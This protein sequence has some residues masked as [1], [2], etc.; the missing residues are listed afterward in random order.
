MGNIAPQ[1][2]GPTGEQRDELRRSI[3]RFARLLPPGAERNQFRYIAR[4][5][6][7]FEEGPAS[8]DAEEKNKH[9]PSFADAASHQR[10]DS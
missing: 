4:S 7:F 2:G 10:R 8:G 9:A 5:L 6:T 3:L 1:D